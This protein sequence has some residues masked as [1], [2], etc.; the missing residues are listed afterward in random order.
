M[1]KLLKFIFLFTLFVVSCYF[2]Y[3]YFILLNLKIT[4]SELKFASTAFFMGLF[5]TLFFSEIV[6]NKLQDALEIYK[7]QLEKTSIGSSE[8]NSKV[9][10][11][12]SKIKVLEKALEDALNK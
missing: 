6:I 7:R 10:V 4:S 11:L 5:I 2:A 1:K 12:E 9:K 3:K 8:S